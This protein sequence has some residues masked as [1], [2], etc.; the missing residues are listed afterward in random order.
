MNPREFHS[1]ALRLVEQGNFPSECR[2][3]ISRA[4]YA[5][6]NV[7][8]ELLKSM[9]FD[10]NEGPGGHGDVRHHLNN[11]G[12]N[13]L[14]RVASQ[15]ADLQAK[16]Q[17]ADYYLN[18]VDVENKDTAKAVVYQAKKMI[19]SLDLNCNG[20][21]RD[22]IVKSIRAWKDKISLA[23]KGNKSRVTH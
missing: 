9:N 15:L 19:E 14:M 4:Y 10:I 18:R 5:V 17:H 16:R 6:Y 12:D 2:T 13:D 8:V 1:L 11:S 23:S 21:N 22:L 7:G 20:E 3:A